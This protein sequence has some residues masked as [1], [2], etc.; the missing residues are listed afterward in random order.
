[1]VLRGII[2]FETTGLNKGRRDFAISIGTLITDFDTNDGTIEC[3]DSLYSLIHIPNPTMVKD[4]E[5]IHG[6][7]IEEVT[8]APDSSYVCSEFLKL[9]SQHKLRQAAAWY[10]PFDKGFFERLFERADVKAPVLK[11]N[12][13]Q[14]RSFAKL[15]DFTPLVKCDLV[16][17][18]PAH[19]A[20]RDCAR[21]LCVY[22]E[23]NGYTLDIP[24]LSNELDSW[25]CLR[26]LQ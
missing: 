16:R 25:K 10:Y 7:T 4:T 22:A 9:K 21:A 11:W 13:L 6:I 17:K 14:P 12:E 19:H 1:M 26:N 8:K 18:L 24:S 15:D 20:L 23:N 3:I 5:H 2:D